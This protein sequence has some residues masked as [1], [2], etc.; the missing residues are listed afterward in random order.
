M[1][2]YSVYM[3]TLSSM[4]IMRLPVYALGHRM[5]YKH[6]TVFFL[7]LSVKFF[8]GRSQTWFDRNKWEFCLR[9]PRIKIHTVYSLIKMCFVWVQ[10]WSCSILLVYVCLYSAHLFTFNSEIVTNLLICMPC[11]IAPLASFL[12]YGLNSFSIIERFHFPMQYYSFSIYVECA[13][14]HTVNLIG[15]N[16]DDVTTANPFSSPNI[17]SNTHNHWHRQN[18]HIRDIQREKKLCESCC[19]HNIEQSEPFR[20]YGVIVLY[21][22]ESIWKWKCM[23]SQMHLRSD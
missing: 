2:C 19:W 11:T 10:E 15:R 16:L 7:I 3:N 14:C 17:H 4:S 9:A 20:I 6:F 12:G 21:L 1:P 18:T 8:F 22:F 23:G 13:R 5:S